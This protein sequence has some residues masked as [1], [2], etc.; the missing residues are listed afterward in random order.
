[1]RPTRLQNHLY[2]VGHFGVSFMGYVIAAW[3][4]KFYFPN[5][6]EDVNLVPALLAPWIMGIGRA[7]DGINDPIIGYLSDRVRTRWGRRKPF[8]IV[9]LPMACAFFMMLWYPPVQ[10]ESV[11]NFWFGS[12]VLVLH[13]IGFTIY[14]GPYLAMLPEVARE[15]EERVA[16][17]GL[18]GIYNVSGLIAGAFVTGAALKAGMGYQGM[19]WLVMGIAAV[20]Y[21]LPLFGPRDDPA[22][23]ADQTTPPFFRSLGMTFANRPFRVYV[24][25]KLMFLMGLLL[26]VAALPYAVETLLGV[27]KGEAGTISGLALLSGILCVPLIL[28]MARRRTTE[29]AYRFSMLWFAASAS[30]LALMAVFGLYPFGVWLARGSVLV[31]GVAVGGLFALPYAILSDVTDHDRAHTGADRQGMYFCV[32]GLILKAAYGGAPIVVVGLLALFPHH[33]ATVLTLVGPMAGLLAF[34]A[35]AVFRHYPQEEVRKAVAEAGSI[36]VP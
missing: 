10:S 12:I 18:Q 30:L 29:A 7:T 28:K 11:A 15:R 22:R 23:V 33:D 16:L 25:S 8:M 34:A 36:A 31:M 9:G 1:M 4:M 32:Q 5:N 19:A 14:T 2:A 20:A 13:F 3:V 27:D 35:W 17:A 24:T 6:P 26:I 21:A